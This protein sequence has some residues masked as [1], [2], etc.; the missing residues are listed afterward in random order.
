VKRVH[1]ISFKNANNSDCHHEC[2]T[3]QI[4]D[5]I[6]KSNFNHIG[7]FVYLLEFKFGLF[8]M[9][10]Y[11]FTVLYAEVYKHRVTS[12]IPLGCCRLP[13]DN[14]KKDGIVVNDINQ[15]HP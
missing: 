7:I 14:E 6:P 5:V 9:Y 1:E 4:K 8:E 12:V 15:Y 10:F 2:T 13:E 11:I 3:V